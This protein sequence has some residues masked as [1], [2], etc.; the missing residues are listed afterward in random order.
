MLRW[1]PDR[2]IRLYRRLAEARP[3]APS[4]RPRLLVEPDPPKPGGRDRQFRLHIV[5]DAF[6]HHRSPPRVLFRTS[7]PPRDLTSWCDTP[8]AWTGRRRPR[9]PSCEQARAR[10]LA[11]RDKDDWKAECWL[12][13]QAKRGAVR[14]LAERRQY[15]HERREALVRKREAEAIDGKP[16]MPVH[17]LPDLWEHIAHRGSVDGGYHVRDRRDVERQLVRA[18][19]R[20]LRCLEQG[21]RAR[22]RDLAMQRERP[23]QAATAPPPDQPPLADPAGAAA[24]VAAQAD[25][26]A[27]GRDHAPAADSS[28]GRPASARRKAVR[29]S[30]PAPRANGPTAASDPA[31]VDPAAVASP[32]AGAETSTATGAGQPPRGRHAPPRR[33]FAEQSVASFGSA[34]LAAAAGDR[35]RA[36]GRLRHVFAAPSDPAGRAAGQPGAGNPTPM[37]PATPPAPTV[38]PEQPGQDPGG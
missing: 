21:R 4:T 19:E 1:L 33:R 20:H 30:H 35:R 14:L 18:H 9:C 5:Y 27:T 10:Y 31:A 2:L 38:A 36:G 28:A 11:A 17:F 24:S 6:C 8:N 37:H 15:R 13:R 32:D 26:H 22:L 29:R 34:G 23:S 7:I 3:Y 12:Y 25:A 16:E